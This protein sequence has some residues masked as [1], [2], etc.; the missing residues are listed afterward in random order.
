MQNKISIVS[1]NVGHHNK[2][3]DNNGLTIP[4]I[5]FLASNDFTVICIQET[6]A[7]DNEIQQLSRFLQPAKYTRVTHTAKTT[8]AA[9]VATFVKDGIQAISKWRQR[10]TTSFDISLANTDT[11]L[12][13]INTYVHFQDKSIGAADDSLL[14]ALVK[15]AADNIVII[16]GDLNCGLK[17]SNKTQIYRPWH[18]KL[19]LTRFRRLIPHHPTPTSLQGQGSAIGVLATP[20]VLLLIADTFTTHDLPIPLSNA[21]KPVSITFPLPA[22]IGTTAKPQPYRR[23]PLPT[24]ENATRHAD[25][26]DSL[27]STIFE[28]TTVKEKSRP[29]RGQALKAYL[30]TTATR[31]LTQLSTALISNP[32][33]IIMLLADVLP[34]DPLPTDTN[35]TWA[36]ALESIRWAANPVDETAV[37]TLFSTST[38][39]TPG[40]IALLLQPITVTDILKAKGQWQHKKAF[41]DFKVEVLNTLSTQALETLATE[42]STW[43]TSFPARNRL[44]IGLRKPNQRPRDQTENQHEYL[45]RILRPIGIAPAFHALF[46]GIFGSRLSLACET[47]KVFCDATAGFRPGRSTHHIILQTL[48]AIHTAHSLDKPFYIIK[49]DISKAYDR[50]AFET[51]KETAR[52]LGI[53][54]PITTM[55]AS[56][57]TSPI[58]VRATAG[59][60]GVATPRCGHT[61]GEAPVCQLFPLNIE[62]AVYRAEQRAR[63][64]DP[65]MTLV[66]H[67]QFA[68]DGITTDTQLQRLLTNFTAFA[69]DIATLG[70][71]ISKVEIA[72]NA[73]GRFM[74][75]ETH[76]LGTIRQLQTTIRLLGAC[77]HLDQPATGP[78]ADHHCCICQGP[79]KFPLC[80]TCQPSVVNGIRTWREAPT[81]K[82]AILVQQLYPAL[83]YAPYSCSA[84]REFALSTYRHT[85]RALTQ[86]NHQGLEAYCNLPTQMG[87]IGLP[88]MANYI[89]AHTV[90]TLLRE[91]QPTTHQARTTTQMI[92]KLQSKELCHL[93]PQVLMALGPFT[94]SP[95][96][97]PQQA[98]PNNTVYFHFTHQKTVTKQHLTKVRQYSTRQQPLEFT[99][100]LT[101]ETTP[102]QHTM[103]SYVASRIVA[104]YP[105]HQITFCNLSPRLQTDITTYANT[106]PRKRIRNPAS[107]ELQYLCFPTIRT[108]TWDTAPMQLKE[109]F[110]TTAF[111]PAG[112]K[113]AFEWFRNTPIL[114]HPLAL[115]HLG[116][117]CPTDAHTFVKQIFEEQYQTAICS[118][119]QYSPMML[120][121]NWEMSQYCLHYKHFGARFETMISLTDLLLLHALRSCGACHNGDNCL[122][123]FCPDPQATLSLQ[124][125]WTHMQ[126]ETL[127]DIGAKINSIHAGEM[128]LI[129]VPPH[130]LT[131]SLLNSLGWPTGDFSAITQSKETKF[132]RHCLHKLLNVHIQPYLSEAR[133]CLGISNQGHQPTE[134]NPNVNKTPPLEKAKWKLQSDASLNRD[135]LSGGIGGVIL[136]DDLK[137]LETWAPVTK[138]DATDITTVEYEATH[139]ILEAAIHF[140]RANPLNVPKTLVDIE[141]DNQI[142]TQQSNHKW[143]TKNLSHQHAKDR[144]RAF[145]IQ[146]QEEQQITPRI[147]WIPRT[148][149]HLADKAAARGV[150][151]TNRIVWTHPAYHAPA[152]Y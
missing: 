61:Q 56:H 24:L 152:P 42:M 64:V 88:N 49:S 145:V 52:A 32:R 16:I 72:A 149:N 4:F 21:H 136:L 65:S 133:L 82:A 58:E 43:F 95:N 74:I 50:A 116:S 120:Q 91:L 68:D 15:E 66:S 53:L 131:P 28:H 106:D 89:A 151:A 20:E 63:A 78:C 142:A 110:L 27:I 34:A 126:P 98:S 105:H 134:V 112:T 147:N 103:E 123:P 86:L 39:L 113:P 38:P 104:M 107:T 150:K 90:R 121:P 109:I 47:S 129:S 3:M 17:P 100:H 125:I 59:K 1:I 31:T 115:R 140:F 41:S 94:M 11:R 85:W 122:H 40:S 118:A 14:Q 76:I 13:I 44:L 37:K 51:Q 135:G 124:H 114:T 19:T 29:R 102:R 8:N 18:Q 69:E 62:P 55:M 117:P 81:S 119:S 12:T 146:L 87:G 99:I 25:N 141:S 80:E 67:C 48:M 57:T 7:T 97:Y 46:M 5:N 111:L 143:H 96:P 30:R 79:S 75:H 139:L 60:P 23:S 33:R 84:Q 148:K 35:S 71:T 138:Q 77:V 137:I 9:G 6:H 93:P 73:K 130:L 128:K 70:F 108:Y 83:A 45:L 2:L 144:T 54:Q 22:D 26:Y 10:D 92:S 36:E 132:L 101:D 127:V